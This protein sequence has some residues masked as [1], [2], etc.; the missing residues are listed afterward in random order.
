MYVY[1]FTESILFLLF[2][3]KNTTKHEYL[4]LMYV[5]QFAAS[6][7]LHFWGKNGKNLVFRAYLCVPVH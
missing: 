1:R 7:F 5:Y 6:M 4:G 3:G 2:R